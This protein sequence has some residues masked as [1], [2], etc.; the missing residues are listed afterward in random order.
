MTAFLIALVIWIAISF[1]MCWLWG[2]MVRLG[3]TDLQKEDR[4]TPP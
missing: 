2:R 1:F 4:E 3:M